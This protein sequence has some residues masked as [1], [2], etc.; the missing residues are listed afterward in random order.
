MNPKNA[1]TENKNFHTILGNVNWCCI[2]TT[3]KLILRGAV[4]YREQRFAAGGAVVVG[5]VSSI[6]NL[7]QCLTS[8]TLEQQWLTSETIR[9]LSLT[10]GT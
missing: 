4:Y 3:R 8:V 10:S 9:Q 7:A 1:C 5:Q 2:S 6:S